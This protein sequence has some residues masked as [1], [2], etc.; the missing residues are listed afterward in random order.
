M[1][2]L[3]EALSQSAFR[4]CG[5]VFITSEYFLISKGVHVVGD[6]LVIMRPFVVALF[7]DVSAFNV[8]SHVKVL[9]FI[10]QVQQTYKVRNLLFH[11]EMMDRSGAEQHVIDP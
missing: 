8:R 11:L 7:I 2:S 9:N 6:R 1:Y 10:Y 4:I 3:S 5:H